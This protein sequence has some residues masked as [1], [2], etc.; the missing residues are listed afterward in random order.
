MDEILNFD[1]LT[2][3]W[4]NLNAKKKE[5]IHHVPGSTTTYSKYYSFPVAYKNPS[6]LAFQMSYPLSMS[7][8]PPSKL[9]IVLFIFVYLL[10][11]VYM[12]PSFQS[13]D[14]SKGTYSEI[15]HSPCSMKWC[16]GQSL[17]LPLLSL[18]SF[19]LFSIPSSFPPFSVFPSSFSFYLPSFPPLFLF[20][21]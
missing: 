6:A 18:P 13:S 16:S 17:L 15:L 14:C 12:L 4:Y 21:I 2:W 1:N 3:W 8:I 7:N 19:L 20:Q 11:H 5:N 9:C 10:P